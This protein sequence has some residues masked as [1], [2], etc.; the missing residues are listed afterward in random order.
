MARCGT[1]SGGPGHYGDGTDAVKCVSAQDGR[2]I[3]I[4][5][6]FLCSRGPR[7]ARGCDTG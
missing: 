1:R 7:R 3:P 4:T 6:T 5:K 2:L